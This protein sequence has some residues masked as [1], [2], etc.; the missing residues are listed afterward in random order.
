[1]KITHFGFFVLLASSQ[2]FAGG[3]NKAADIALKSNDLK[4]YYREL[5]EYGG[6]KKQCSEMLDT[7]NQE[8][9]NGANNY[10]NQPDQSD[11]DKAKI[12]CNETEHLSKAA[13]AAAGVVY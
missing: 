10:A 8:L 1:M 9:A 4:T 5:A 3:F 7:W 2:S 11:F 6:S 13:K 12:K